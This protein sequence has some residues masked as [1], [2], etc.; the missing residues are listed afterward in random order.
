MLKTSFKG[1]WFFIKTIC[2][3]GN[4]QKKVIENRKSLKHNI[5]K[6]NEWKNY[7]DRILNFTFYLYQ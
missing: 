1:G 2:D 7:L 4:S 6:I 3:L 5:C